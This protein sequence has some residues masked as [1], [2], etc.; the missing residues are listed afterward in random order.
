LSSKNK[1]KKKKRVWLGYRMPARFYDLIDKILPLYEGNLS[2]ALDA[3]LTNW[4]T[5]EFHREQILTLQAM[6]YRMLELED[7]PPK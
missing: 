4:E 7:S 5:S 2:A 3:I 6:R 1:K